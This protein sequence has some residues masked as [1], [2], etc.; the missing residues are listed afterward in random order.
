MKEEIIRIVHKNSSLSYEEYNSD[1]EN[2]RLHFATRENG[3][4]LEEQYS[5]KDLNSALNAEMHLRR[6][7]GDKL[8]INI[9]PCDEWVLMEV[10]FL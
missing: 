3:D 2:N 6:L 8:K 5:E 9:E 10:T 1:L 4:I 7:F